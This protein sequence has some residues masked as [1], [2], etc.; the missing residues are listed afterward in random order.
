M[1]RGEQIGTIGD[2]QALKDWICVVLICAM[3]I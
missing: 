3:S 1:D 2:N